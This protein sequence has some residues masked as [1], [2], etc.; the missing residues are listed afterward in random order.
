MAFKRLI[1]CT[2]IAAGL[3]HSL[4]GCSSNSIPD[5]IKIGAAQPLTGNKAGQGQDLLNGVKLAVDELNKA[6]F[7]VKGKSVTLE[8]LAVDDRASPQTGVEVAKQ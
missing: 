8:V 1:T 6:G 2:F 3:T 5:V 7:K 4:L